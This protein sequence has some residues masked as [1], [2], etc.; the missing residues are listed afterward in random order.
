MTA[1]FEVGGGVD[2]E[3]YGTSQVGQIGV[4][5]IFD[6]HLTLLLRL[7]IVLGAL[8]GAIFISAL[9]ILAQYFCFEILVCFLVLFEFGVELENVQIVLGIDLVI[10]A[11]RLMSDLVL[12]LHQV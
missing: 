10:Q 2:G 8:I 9:F 7:F 1:L 4:R 11:R 12:F 6:L 5:L 3:V